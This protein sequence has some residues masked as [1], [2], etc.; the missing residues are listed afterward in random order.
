M[1][2]KGIRQL[3]EHQGVRGETDSDEFL[4]EFYKHPLISSLI[5]DKHHPAYIA[6][7]TFV[8]V[9][10][11]I[12]TAAKPGSVDFGDFENGSK[13]LPDGNVKRSILALVQRSNRDLE[14]VQLAVEGWFNDAMD[15][16]NGWY[17]RRTQLWTIIIALFLTLV[18][19]ANTINAIQCYAPRC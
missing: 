6:P 14:S 17:K 3:L 12:L 15:R 18:A 16:V 2:N 9:I 11:D 5:H 1:L 8:A 10:T 7:R 19:N 13:E 4:R